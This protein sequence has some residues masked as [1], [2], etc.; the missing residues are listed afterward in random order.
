[1]H[2]KLLSIL[3]LAL[4]GASQAAQAAPWTYRGSLNDGGKPANGSY[5]LRLT[6]T[7]AAGVRAIGQPLTLY[8]VAVK[9]GNFAADVDFGVDLS[10]APALKLKT[11]VAQGG[12]GFVSLGEATRFDPMAVLAGI[13]WD[14]TGN[15]VAAGEFLGATNNVAV[16]IK[17]NNLR[18]AQFKAAGTTASYG[19]APQVALGSSANLASG[20]GATVGGGG[21]TRDLSGN[22]ISIGL[23]AATARFATVSG[24]FGNSAINIYSTVG[25]GITN[26]AGGNGGTVGG[27][28]TNQANGDFNTIAGGQNNTTDAARSTVAGGEFNRASAD[29]AAV[30]GGSGNQAWGLS[31]AVVG[32]LGNVADGEFST[33][34]GGSGN[35]AG[36]DYS[37]AGGHFARVR[38]AVSNGTTCSASSGDA[39][40]D[41]GTFVWADDQFANFISTGRRQ[42][43][44]RAGG[45]MAINTNTPAAST[46]LT[47]AGNT[48]LQGNTDTTGNIAFGS[49][50]RQMLNLFSTSY[51]IGIQAA[52]MYFRAAGT[53]GFSWFEGGVHSNTTDDPGAGGT[54]RMRLTAAGQLQTTTG[55]IST[56]SDARLKSDVGN[57]SGALD[58]IA[59]LRPV[60]Y[61]YTDAAKAPF[62]PEGTHLGFIAQEVQQVFPEWVSQDESGYL[63]LSMRGFEAVAVRGMQELQA[64]NAALR[65]RLDAI[66]AKLARRQ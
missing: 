51:G 23:N 28:M 31:S 42:F 43:L 38:T 3:I 61:R 37:W 52:R 5:D 58:Q 14:T 39:D 27:G 57:Y 11:E 40:G 13:C 12:S 8:G 6:L 65:A 10:N 35:C 64:E 18:A 53:G 21:A 59:A 46:S 56:L 7:D 45:G 9:D 60:H 30:S 55:T 1:M 22:P 47:V 36:G 49:V 17:A 54:L 4:L 29:N 19:D 26:T 24:G 44:V 25:G 16:E 50:T 2:S 41:E 15:V 34:S 48:S 20:I 32:G 66:E 33:V 62:Q 63:M